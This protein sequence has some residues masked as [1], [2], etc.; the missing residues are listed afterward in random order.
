MAR[1]H[2]IGFSFFTLA[3]LVL[4]GVGCVPQEK[5]NA[6]RLALDAANERFATADAQARAAKAESDAYKRQLDQLAANGNN[7]NGL[8]SNLTTQLTELQSQYAKLQQDYENAMNQKGTVQLLP[9]PLTNALTE[10]ANQNPDL[11]DFDSGR[12]I[13]KFKSDVTFTAGSAELRPEARTAI[14]KFA[15]ILNSPA[16]KAYELQVAGHTDSQRVSNPA[17]IKAGHHDNWYLSSHRAISVGKALQSQQVDS[18]RIAVVGYADQ[19][20]I[21]S[22]AS[23]QGRAQNRRVEVL[24]LPNQVRTLTAD[25]A[26]PEAQPK[27]SAGKSAPELNKDTTGAEVDRGPAFNK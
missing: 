3:A 24:I 8:V 18:R 4:T 1:M 2:S 11:V 5:Y 15:Q 21:A 25:A 23:E 17:T 7:V 19:H 10:F 6:A 9:E 14:S 26:A 16:A 13:V 12:G 22:N 20:P 27:R